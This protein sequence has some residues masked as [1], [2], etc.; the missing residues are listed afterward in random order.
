MKA[1]VFI[2]ALLLSANILGIYSQKDLFSK[3]S[4]N[5]HITSVTITKALLN[6]AP[7]FIGN[8]MEGI[9]IS[10]LIG[11]LEQIDI[12]TSEDKET[13]RQMKTLI[14]ND[15]AKNKAYE[16]LMKIKDKTDNITFYAEKEKNSFK[17]LIMLIGEAEEC[18]LIRIKGNFTAEDL[19]E[20]TKNK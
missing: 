13:S 15:I 20:I 9:E 14:E 3:L 17:S 11:K 12:F 10:K 7:A 19:Q 16:T 6:M 2:T 8:S 18:T 4:D 5:Q 1:K